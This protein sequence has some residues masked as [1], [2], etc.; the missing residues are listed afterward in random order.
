V[1]YEREATPLWHF[2]PKK[3][4]TED[5]LVKITYDNGSVL[6]VRKFRE[7]W[8]VDVALMPDDLRQIQSRHKITYFE[9]IRNVAGTRSGYVGSAL[10]LAGYEGG[11]LGHAKLHCTSVPVVADISPSSRPDVVSEASP[12]FLASGDV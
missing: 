12:L 9:V 4:A 3:G 6:Y 10:V 11:A 5:D 7:C 2:H 8:I 1:G